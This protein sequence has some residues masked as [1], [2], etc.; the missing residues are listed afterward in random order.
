M[1][2][3]QV[4]YVHTFRSGKDCCA[5]RCALLHEGVENMGEQ[6]ARELLKSFRFTKPGIALVHRNQYNDM[7]QLQVNEFARDIISGIEQWLTD[8]A[9]DAEKQAKLAELM[10]IYDANS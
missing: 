8:I 10:E 3:K 7:L 5:L 9:G 4:G 1:G 2:P 6:R